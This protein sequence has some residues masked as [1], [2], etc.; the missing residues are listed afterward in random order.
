MCEKEAARLITLK[1]CAEILQFATDCSAKQLV[2][3]AHQFIC[4]NLATLLE[5]RILDVLSEGCLEGLTQYYFDAFPTLYHRKI[6]PY[7]DAPPSE[8]FDTF[9]MPVEEILE[10]E[11]DLEISRRQQAHLATAYAEVEVG[12]KQKS[13]NSQKQRHRTV[14]GSEGDSSGGENWNVS[15][16][17][18]RRH[19]KPSSESVSSFGSSDSEDDFVAVGTSRSVVEPDSDVEDFGI[20]ERPQEAP[21]VKVQDKTNQQRKSSEFMSSLLRLPRQ[22]KPCTVLTVPPV[23]RAPPK[24][25]TANDETKTQPTPCTPSGKLTKFTKLS[26]K[27]RKRLSLEQVE[28]QTSPPTN[29]NKTEKPTWSGWGKNHMANEMIKEVIDCDGSTLPENMTSHMPLPIKVVFMGNGHQ[30]PI[31][32]KIPKISN[33][34]TSWRT[35]SFEEESP[36]LIVPAALPSVNPWY[37]NSTSEAARTS[38]DSRLKDI[39][40]L[41]DREN[42][43]IENRVSTFKDIMNQEQME[44]FSL[45]KAQSKSLTATQLE[46]K[47]IEELKV[48]YNV[49]N[50]FD[51][52]IFVER[53]SDFVLATPV[54][55]PKRKE[56][57]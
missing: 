8:Y 31:V 6:T 44:K 36:T 48:F 1:N 41:S 3:T 50:T 40:K 23:L 32:D 13:G 19:R 51:E 21:F 34:K 24:I 47:A 18:Q 42:Q 52:F 39:Q 28:Y 45:Y 2:R 55:N 56:F 30:E 25:A 14:S 54:W 46:E 37:K 9:T 57:A 15:K 12:K 43:N 49:E 10:M 35:L 4:Q 38:L 17:N 20:V 53:A 7:W 16:R 29:E 26:Q 27:E 22:E 11:S 33:K 5:A